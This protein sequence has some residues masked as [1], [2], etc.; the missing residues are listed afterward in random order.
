MSKAHFVYFARR[1]DELMTE[2]PEDEG[3]EYVI[4]KTIELPKVEYENFA[5]DL[6]PERGFIEKNKDL[7]RI[8]SDIFHCVLVRE[9]DESEGV[10]VMSDGENFPF[11][12]ALYNEK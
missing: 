12:V 11:L 10:L 5:S 3:K 6:R 4:E 2:Y 9:Q 8:E 7:C 1:I